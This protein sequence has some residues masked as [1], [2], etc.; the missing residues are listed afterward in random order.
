VLSASFNTRRTTRTTTRQVREIL[1]Q[2]YP[3][4]LI[5]CGGP[6]HWPVRSYC[7][8]ATGE[9][10]RSYVQEAFATITPE[11]V[12][13]SKLNLLRLARLCLQMNGGHFE[14]FL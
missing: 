10:F 11:M 9:Q 6:Q 8:I 13:N 14:H 4:R 5:S 3:H 1:D 2:Q 12:T 7:L